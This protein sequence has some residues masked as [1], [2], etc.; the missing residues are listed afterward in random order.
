MSNKD[1]TLF[2]FPCA[3]PLKVMGH[4]KAGFENHVRAIVARHVE[5]TEILDCTCR[6]SRNGN[7]LSVTVTIQAQSKQQLDQLYIELN[8]SDAVLM[9]L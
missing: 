8:A 9:T 1:K 6:P 3:F 2:E 4:D 7:F 5:E